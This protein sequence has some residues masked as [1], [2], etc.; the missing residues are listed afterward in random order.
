[1]G[2]HIDAGLRVVH[3]IPS[4]VVGIVVHDKVIAR[5]IPAPVG[6]ER[7]IE[8]GDLKGKT[9][10]EPKAAMIAVKPLDMVAV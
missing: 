9:A 3:R 5:A 7:P 1:L 2:V 8:R 6:G 4:R 10:G